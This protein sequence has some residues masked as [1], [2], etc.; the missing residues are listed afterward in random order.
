MT[1]VLQPWVQELS[2]MQQ[3][4]LICAIRGE[5]GKFKNDPSKPIVRY[6][7]RCILLSAFDGKALWGTHEEGGGSF[8]GPLPDGVDFNQAC[9]W[10]LDARDSMHL[11]YY[12]HVTHAVEIL[13]YKHPDRLLS[14]RWHYFYAR[15]VNALHLRGELEADMD[16]RLSDQRDEWLKRSDYSEHT[17]ADRAHMGKGD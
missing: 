8:T 15:L 5:D 14:S 16:L 2:F 9:T 11:H 6:M 10:F 3:S 1:S 7:R 13:G 17:E 12:M 4:V